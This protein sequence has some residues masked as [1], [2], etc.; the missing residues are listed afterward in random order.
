MPIPLHYEELLDYAQQHKAQLLSSTEQ[1]DL[2]LDTVTRAIK[3]IHANDIDIIPYVQKINVLIANLQHVPLNEENFVM[4]LDQIRTIH[5]KGLDLSKKGNT[6]AWL[7]GKMQ[8]AGY[9]LTGFGQCLGIVYMATQSFFLKDMP[10]FNHR[11]NLIYHLPQDYFENEFDNPKKHIKSLIAQNNLQEAAKEQEQLNDIKAFFEGVALY[12]SAEKHAEWFGT[13]VPKQL[14]LERSMPYILPNSLLR[15]KDNQPTYIRS[16]LGQTYTLDDVEELLTVLGST[17]SDESYTLHFKDPFHT[18]ALFYDA[19]LKKWFHVQ[20]DALPGEEIHTLRLLAPIIFSDFQGLQKE[21]CIDLYAQEKD[22]ISIEVKIDTLKDNEGW[23]QKYLTNPFKKDSIHVRQAIMNVIEH[24]RYEWFEMQIKKLEEE[25]IYKLLLSMHGLK[26][27]YA[28]NN[29]E[30]PENT[31][32]P[33]VDI[34][35]QNISDTY[36]LLY[37]VSVGN[38]ELCETL[39][40]KGV[41]PTTHVLKELD[42]SRY[43][44]SEDPELKHTI[45]TLLIQHYPVQTDADIERLYIPKSKNNDI[46]VELIKKHYE[47]VPEKWLLKSIEAQDHRLLMELLDLEESNV[48][49]A[50]LTIII[51]DENFHHHLNDAIRCLKSIHIPIH[52][53]ELLN[54]FFLISSVSSQTLIGLIHNKQLPDKET[55]SQVLIQRKTSI[56]KGI[57]SLKDKLMCQKLID[58]LEQA[59]RLISSDLSHK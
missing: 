36:K 57:H 37:A 20:P 40:Q 30:L 43:L 41:I 42:D 31:L 5:L 28:F 17:L 27:S 24:Q 19:D 48:T 18:A 50:V 2:F 33:L 46:L 59:Q 7:T 44:N 49:E 16:F 4:L 1:Q 11:L 25:T 29:M 21:F 58:E 15:P 52:D 9:Q 23:H 3:F 56:G 10:I 39:I 38:V 14:P 54:K 51:E 45:K 34:S 55:I 35:L 26:H 32:D 8:A 12:S 47:Q 6:Q 53:A 22:K 13:T